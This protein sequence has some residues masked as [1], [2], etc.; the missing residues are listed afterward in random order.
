MNISDKMR[1]F[2]NFFF[3]ILLGLVTFSCTHSNS[4]TERCYTDVYRLDFDL[5]KRCENG[6]PWLQNPVYSN[7][8][9]PNIENEDGRKLLKFCGLEGFPIQEMNQ[10][11][12]DWNVK[13]II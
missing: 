11:K 4:V 1:R 9:I 3:L 13:G 2:M 6:Y 8:H 12:V 7:F 10:L 5:S